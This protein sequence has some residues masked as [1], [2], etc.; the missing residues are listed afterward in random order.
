MKCPKCGAEMGCE[1]PLTGAPAEPGV[2]EAADLE[3]PGFME[4]TS[5]YVCPK[6]GTRDEQTDWWE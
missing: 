2:P 6:C 1:D 4:V 5:Y 3:K